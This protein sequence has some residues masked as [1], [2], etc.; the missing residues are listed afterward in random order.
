MP[1]IP[2]PPPRG[3]IPGLGAYHDA[4]IDM[5]SPRAGQ[6]YTINNDT[7]T[8]DWYWLQ[9]HIDLNEVVEEW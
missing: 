9:N 1:R 5:V 4:F 3:F 7:F 2:L 8:W 6:R